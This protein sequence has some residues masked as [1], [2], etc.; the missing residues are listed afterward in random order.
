MELMPKVMKRW[1]KVMLNRARHI[2]IDLS[3]NTSPGTLL[4]G[5]NVIGAESDIQNAVLGLGGYVSEGCRLASTHVGRFCSI[6]PEVAIIRGGHP[7][8]GYAATHPAFFSRRFQTGFTFAKNDLFPEI[9]NAGDERRF[10]VI[11]GNDVWIGQR[12]M[13]MQGV[14]IGNCAIVGAGAL[15]LHNVE[16]YSINVGIPARRVRARLDKKY[17]DFLISFKWWEK[18][19][20]FLS[21][22][23]DLFADVAK[24]YAAFAQESYHEPHRP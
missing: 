15:V 14:T 24:L 9:R 8:G 22:N 11:I 2:R 20:D 10:A 7:T 12:A 17:L 23:A 4:E 3:A 21:Q 13:I 5:Y 6:A 16:P 19:M 18:G 1:A